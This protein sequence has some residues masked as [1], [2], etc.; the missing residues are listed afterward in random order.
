MTFMIKYDNDNCR[1]MN[2]WTR[3][4]DLV[5]V[6]VVVFGTRW[7]WERGVRQHGNGLEKCVA[8]GG[9]C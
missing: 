5:V 9:C 7:G 4:I 8:T 3:K 6:V 1:W 2:R